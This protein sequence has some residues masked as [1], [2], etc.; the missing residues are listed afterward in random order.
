MKHGAVDFLSKPFRE[1]ELLDAIHAGIARDS[2][3]RIE[4]RMREQLRTHF[5]SL[6]PRERE[7]M[8]LVAQGLPNKQIAAAL[9]L[10]DV[11][12]KVHRSHV[13][14]KMGAKSAADLVRMSDQLN[15]SSALSVP[16]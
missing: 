14:L 11:T 6:T 7:I 8:R 10:S 15:D 1:Q 5:E 12:V 16:T 4:T 2:K 3:R 9:S 13:M